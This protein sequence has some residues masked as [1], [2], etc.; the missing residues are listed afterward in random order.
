MIG[1]TVGTGAWSAAAHVAAT[2]MQIMTGLTCYVMGDDEWTASRQ[3]PSWAKTGAFRYAGEN[4]DVMIF[5]ADLYCMKPWSPVDTLGH[6]DV[7]CVAEQTNN[8]NAIECQLY[9]IPRERYGN[10][11][12][13]ILSHRAKGV[14]ATIDTYHPL[15]GKYWEQNPLNVALRDLGTRV[16][17]LPRAYNDLI[18]TDTAPAITELEDRNSINLHFAGPKDPMKLVE[19]Y[20]QLKT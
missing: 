11:G 15:Y 6:K 9:G 10:G 16:R 1:V 18:R 14:L 7:A 5:D 8:L 17:W 3:H 4:E 19:L 13:V 12:L 2:R 20:A